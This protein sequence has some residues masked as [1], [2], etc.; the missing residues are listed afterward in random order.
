M[1]IHPIVSSTLE[2]E[3]KLVIAGVCVLLCTMSLQGHIAERYRK[4]A[5]CACCLE[6]EGNFGV[7]HVVYMCDF[8]TM[9]CEIY[10]EVNQICF[11]VDNG[12]VTTSTSP[13]SPVLHYD[14]N[15]CI[16]H[17]SLASNS[18]TFPCGDEAPTPESY[19]CLMD[20][21]LCAPHCPA[22]LEWP[23][24]HCTSQIVVRSVQKTYRGRARI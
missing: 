16:A 11:V 20:G 19:V 10:C 1:Y 21:S 23:N 22:K 17:P 2:Y 12:D 13:C 5:L 7:K 6:V 24:T 8:V 14:N 15:V 18:L 4:Q 9:T 3:M